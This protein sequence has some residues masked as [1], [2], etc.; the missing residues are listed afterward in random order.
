VHDPA[1]GPLAIDVDAPDGVYDVAAG[2]VPIAPPP[3][4]FGFE[5]WLRKS[6][7]NTAPKAYVPLG[8]AT[9][10]AGR[11][12]IRLPPGTA[13]NQ[14]VVTIRLTPPG[15]G[16]SGKQARDPALDERLRRLGYVE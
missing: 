16:E 3:W 11:L 13:R 7:R 14:H 4:F 15:A 12:R 6:F 8:Q 9:A 5:R 10:Q 2:V 1:D